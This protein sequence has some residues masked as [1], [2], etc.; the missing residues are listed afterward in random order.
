MASKLFGNVKTEGVERSEDRTGSSFSLFDSDIY[1]AVI[2]AAYVTTAS[3]SAAQALNLIFTIEDKEYKET[4]WV[5]NKN[6]ECSFIDK[7]NDKQ[8]F[9]PGWQM[10]NDIAMMTTGEEF[11]DCEFEEK[12]I[13][14]Y[15]YDLKQETPTSVPMCTA[16]V[17]KKILL[18]IQKRIVNKQEKSADGSYIDTDDTKEENVLDKVFH[19]DTRQTLSE[20]LQERDAGFYEKWLETNKG[21]TRDA[22]KNKSGNTAKPSAKAPEASAKPRPN[23]FGKK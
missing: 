2:K 19:P 15:N 16:M 23:L 9:L 5:T 7:R 17:G 22:R 10:A 18:A 6:G 14:L 1:E 11:R 4:I 8:T 3:S 13:K 20:A 21:K 12:V